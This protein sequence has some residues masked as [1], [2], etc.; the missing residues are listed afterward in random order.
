MAINDEIILAPTNSLT[1]SVSR[2]IYDLEAVLKTV[3]RF[4]DRCYIEL[5][6]NGEIFT[7]SIRR[8]EDNDELLDHIRADFCNE[9]VDQQIRALAEKEFGEIRDQI[10]RKAFSPIT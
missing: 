7:V 8:K 2:D 6:T 5:D 3:H 10:V 1:L 4:I 9:L